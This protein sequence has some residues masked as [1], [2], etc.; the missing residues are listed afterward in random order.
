[1]IGAGVSLL[2]FIIIQSREPSFAHICTPKHRQNFLAAFGQ[3]WKVIYIHILHPKVRVDSG[4]SL[5]MLFRALL[6]CNWIISSCSAASLP[7]S[8][9]ILKAISTWSDSDANGFSNCR[10]Q[11]LSDWWVVWP[12]TLQSPLMYWCA[13][14][15]LLTHSLSQSPPVTELWPWLNSIVVWSET[16]E[17][18]EW[19]QWLLYFRGPH[20]ICRRAACGP[21]AVGWTA[22]A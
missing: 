3:L 21:R 2:R 19:C 22:L 4:E 15:K 16:D 12:I 20:R 14:K 11:M 7:P 5:C 8:S 1:M 9:F 13:V 17:S 6:C 18:C 10:L